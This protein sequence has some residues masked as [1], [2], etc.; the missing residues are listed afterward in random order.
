VYSGIYLKTDPSAATTPYPIIRDVL[1]AGNEFRESTGV[2]AYLTSIKNVTFRDNTFSDTVPR[3]NELAY[4]SQFYLENARDVRIVNNRWIKSACVK[5]PGVEWDP[6]TCE[7]V[8]VQGN[9]LV[10]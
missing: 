8:V 10:D 5:A 9:S 1:F 7:N 3:A 2:I 6:D 4:R